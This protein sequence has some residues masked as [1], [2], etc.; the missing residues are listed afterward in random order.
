M[1]SIGK[2]TGPPQQQ[3]L[4]DHPSAAPEPETGQPGKASEVL[5]TTKEEPEALGPPRDTQAEA[6][7]TLTA[8]TPLTTEQ[9]NPHWVGGAWTQG[10]TAEQVTGKQCPYTKPNRRTYTPVYECEHADTYHADVPISERPH[11]AREPTEWRPQDPVAT[12]LSATARQRLATELVRMFLEPTSAYEPAFCSIAKQFLN[13]TSRSFQRWCLQQTI[14]GSMEPPATAWAS[15]PPIDREAWLLS[16]QILVLVS[17]LGIT[18]VPRV[19]G[20]FPWEFEPWALNQDPRHPTDAEEL[21]NSYTD[22]GRQ[23]YQGLRRM[24]MEW[25]YLLHGALFLAMGAT[26][27]NFDSHARKVAEA[28]KRPDVTSLTLGTEEERTAVECKY[29][30]D[31]V[32]RHETQASG[33]KQI[34]PEEQST[35]YW[36]TAQGDIVGFG[37]QRWCNEAY[38]FSD[39]PAAGN[40]TLRDTA[41]LQHLSCISTGSNYRQ[42]VD[43]RPNAG[44]ARPRI[45]LPT[46]KSSWSGSMHS[47]ELK[48]FEVMAGL[49]ADGV[50][51][52]P[53]LDLGECPWGFLCGKCHPFR[54]PTVG[55]HVPA[56]VLRVAKKA[57]QNAA[58]SRSII[59]EANGPAPANY[60]AGT[61]CPLPFPAGNYILQVQEFTGLLNPANDGKPDQCTEATEF[62]KEY[63]EPWEKS[64]LMSTDRLGNVKLKVWDRATQPTPLAR[65]ERGRKDVFS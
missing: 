27:E 39:V 7:P 62:W 58:G 28:G 15:G 9:Q 37:A 17:R 31:M 16:W 8:S 57:I 55:P 22:A 35:R 11:K 12:G 30:G 60:A 6:K 1:A 36:E 34:P 46:T 13:P 33:E 25:R 61:R 52:A 53:W 50:V 48:V 18:D 21:R 2:R 26:A 4:P 3:V 49:A 64:T 41:C 32:S 59:P 44:D 20:K 45:V 56:N 47:A 42:S 38:N 19:D 14:E 40:R 24:W 54:F 65:H 29:E 43:K 63:P 5:P 51:C 10:V 23:Q